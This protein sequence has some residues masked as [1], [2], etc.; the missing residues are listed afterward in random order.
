[1]KGNI[2]TDDCQGDSLFWRKLFPY[3]L[4][5]REYVLLMELL[6]KIVEN[7]VDKIQKIGTISAIN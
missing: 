3:A 2:E 5:Y 1:M 4:Y 6:G 7:K